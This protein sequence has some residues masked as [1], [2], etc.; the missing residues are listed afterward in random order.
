MKTLKENEVATA[1]KFM[2]F[3]CGGSQLVFEFCLRFDPDQCLDYDLVHR[4]LQRISELKLPAPSPIEHRFTASSRAKMSPAFDPNPNQVFSWIGVVMYL[5]P[6]DNQEEITAEFNRYCD[7]VKQVCDEVGAEIRV[8][9]AKLE[10]DQDGLQQQQQLT[11]LYPVREFNDLRGKVD[12][13]SV[14][15]TSWSLARTWNVGFVPGICFPTD[16]EIYVD[17]DEQVLDEIRVSKPVE[18]KKLLMLKSAQVPPSARLQELIELLVNEGLLLENATRYSILLTK[19]GFDS[20]E[21]LG[22]VTKEDLVACGISAIMDVRLILGMQHTSQMVSKTGRRLSVTKKQSVGVASDSVE[23]QRLLDQKTLA[24]QEKQRLLDQ[25]RQRLLDQERQRLLDQEKQ[26]LL[27]QEKQRLLD[28]EKQRLVEIEEKQRLMEIEE[29]QRLADQE[30]QRVAEIEEKQR[31]ANQEMQRLADQEKQRLADME[32]KQRLEGQQRLAEMEEKQRMAEIEEKQRLAETDEKQRLAE[33]LERQRL[34]ESTEKQLREEKE[35]A[36]RQRQEEEEKRVALEKQRLDEQEEQA[37]ALDAGVTSVFDQEPFQLGRRET[38]ESISSPILSKTEKLELRDAQQ[39]TRQ[40]QRDSNLGET[41]HK[42]SSKD[43]RGAALQM[44]E[45]VNNLK[46]VSVAGYGP[47]AATSSSSGGTP[48]GSD[49][50]LNR[51]ACDKF[52]LNLIAPQ[53]VMCLC[54]FPKIMHN[55]SQSKK[56]TVKEFQPHD[57]ASFATKRQ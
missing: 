7:V 52:R 54:G 3:D 35:Q 6:G 43:W 8:H 31:V 4:L 20:P 53:N 47:D 46:L 18:R 30:K 48:R 27:D 1:D 34:V 29:K 2:A 15:Q 56:K 42:H 21:K 37:S 33:E 26:R 36:E 11:K 50:Q 49:L 19:Q 13:N 57:F 25:E 45:R 14:L 23:K 12:P 32:E 22:N 10:I 41:H 5:P 17:L 39:E 55:D 38:V 51:T 24:G 40:E 44:R 28:Q 16:L 9:W